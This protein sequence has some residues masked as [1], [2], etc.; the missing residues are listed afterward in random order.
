MEYLERLRQEPED[1]TAFRQQQQE[2]TPRIDEDPERTPPDFED[3]EGEN[4]DD[5]G[6][7]GAT[8]QEDDSINPTGESSP[9]LVQWSSV[10]EAAEEGTDHESWVSSGETRLYEGDLQEDS[11]DEAEGAGEESRAST[12]SPHDQGAPSNPDQED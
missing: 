7:G 9:T 6:R 12:Q 3:G 1:I 5:L 10:I 2:Q 11:L 4:E 8:G